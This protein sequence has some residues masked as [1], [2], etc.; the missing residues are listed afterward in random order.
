MFIIGLTG[1]FGT[2]KT[3]VAAMFQKCGAHTIDAD[4]ITHELMGP[5]GK[6]F[7]TI[8]GKSGKDIVSKGKI[9]RRKLA[10]IVFSHP[11]KLKQLT[12]IIHPEVIK[13]TKK[14]IAEI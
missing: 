6:C 9:D 8:I 3:T 12:S 1:S 2:G 5:Q 13:E 14:S 4:Q 10:K 7:K 11:A